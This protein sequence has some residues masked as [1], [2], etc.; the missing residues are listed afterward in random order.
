MKK[1]LLSLTAVV[2][3]GS[4]AASAA[5]LK[6]PVK[7]APPVYV[8]PWDI[9]FGSA[10]ASDYV[11]RG[12]TQS[13]HE[14]S[15]S[16]Y[17]EPRFN[18]NPNFQLY[19]GLAGNSIS[20]TNRAAAEIDIYG[21]ARAT[22]GAFALDVGGWYYW[23]P[24]GEC[25][26]LIAGGGVNCAVGAPNVPN[27][28]TM[29]GDVSF[30]EV[31]GKA[32]YIFNDMFTIGANLFYSPDF[33]NSGA[34]GTYFSGTAKFTGPAFASGMGWYISGELGHQ[35][36]GTTDGFYAFTNLPDYTTWNIGLGLTYKVFTLDLRY[37]GTDLS[38]GDCNAF[39]GDFTA[40]GTTFITPANPG[41]LGS[42]WCD[43]RFVAK[44]SV[45]TSLA[46]IK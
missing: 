30:F 44:F 35:Q 41:G 28:N 20:F 19:A 5:D 21:G 10:I 34:E 46:A 29:K 6:M 40:T 42:N 25:H 32:S 24:G 27:L 22:F 37:S 14:P 15:V 33:L 39:T 8:S 38:K 23:Y 13:N 12:I 17:F 45:D 43:D 31:Y 18:L 2:A 1:L 3:L 16:A 36:L 4:G 26:D 9:A 11:F 7:A